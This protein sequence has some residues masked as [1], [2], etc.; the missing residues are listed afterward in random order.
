MLI[1]SKYICINPHKHRDKGYSTV[2][3]VSC[4]NWLNLHE[5][6]KVSCLTHCSIGMSY[7]GSLLSSAYVMACCLMAS[8]HD[9]NQCWLIV[10]WTIWVKFK[11]KHTNFLARK[12]I[13]KCFLQNMKHFVLAYLC[14]YAPIS[15]VTW[16]DLAH[17][18]LLWNDSLWAY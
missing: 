7:K 14:Y 12:C 10:S 6:Y 5:V 1:Q 18:N 3:T 16:G 17:A 2:S 9:M 13:W 11:P 4:W 15:L 8:H